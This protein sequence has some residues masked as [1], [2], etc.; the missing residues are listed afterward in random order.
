LPTR[1]ISHYLKNNSASIGEILSETTIR[2]TQT[3]HDASSG[4][5]TY[6]DDV[7]GVAAASRKK[8]GGPKAAGFPTIRAILPLPRKLAAKRKRPGRGAGALH[9]MHRDAG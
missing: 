3:C 9:T 8:S 7:F 5:T 2:L 1:Q 4:A 6:S